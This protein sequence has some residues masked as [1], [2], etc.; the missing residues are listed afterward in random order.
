[1]GLKVL[2]LLCA[3]VFAGAALMEVRQL[4]WGR[5]AKK[6]EGGDGEADCENKGKCDGCDKDVD[7]AVTDKA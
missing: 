2:G 7:G 4:T 1:M 5:K 3:G 6:D